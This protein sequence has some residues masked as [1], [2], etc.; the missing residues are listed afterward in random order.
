VC[1]ATLIFARKKAGPKFTQTKQPKPYM[2][3]GG[4]HRTKITS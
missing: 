4:K 3:V 1:L 2:N